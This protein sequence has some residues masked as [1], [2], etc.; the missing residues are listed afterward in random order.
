MRIIASGLCALGLLS[1]HL[2]LAGPCVRPAEKTAFDV[3]GL[4]SELMVTALTCDARD[5]YNAFIGKYRADLG[6]N[7]SALNGYFSRS[8]GRA[9]ST[10]R[11]SYITNLANAQSQAGLRQGT[12]FCQQHVGLFDDVLALPKTGELPVF[13][14]KQSIIQPISVEPCAAQAP[15]ARNRRMAGAT[16]K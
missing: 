15:K 9:A 10:Q 5:K 6:R 14:A 11:D 2:A 7:E 4:K 8:Y 3:A 1:T 16:P 12:A 13:A